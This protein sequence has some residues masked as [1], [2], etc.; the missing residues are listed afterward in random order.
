MFRYFGDSNKSCVGF[1]IVIIIIVIIIVIIII[2]YISF[3]LEYIV[4]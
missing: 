1:I 2:S 4:Q 3:L